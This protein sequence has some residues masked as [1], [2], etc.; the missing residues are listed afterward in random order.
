[1]ND[2][3]LST[4]ESDPAVVW[5]VAVEGKPH[6]PIAAEAVQEGLRSGRFSLNDLAWYTDLPEWAALASL[7]PV[8]R[9]QARGLL[10]SIAPTSFAPSL[11]PELPITPVEPLPDPEKLIDAGF[12]RRTAAWTLDTILLTIVFLPLH[13]GLNAFLGLL[14]RCLYDA[15]MESSS[16]QAT[17]GKR[18]L[19]LRVIDLE[20]QRIRF[21]R[22]LLR[23]TGKG[24]SAFTLGIGF[25]MAGWT[26]RKQALHDF[27]VKTRVVV[28]APHLT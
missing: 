2:R 20:G 26:R 7:K 11:A 3:P 27:I 1:M 19:G 9:W 18:L 23:H 6:G 16:W 25:A 21:G 22:A 13:L 14:L 28:K 15:A 8:Q 17:V 5:Y 24:L 10:S 12:W 4:P